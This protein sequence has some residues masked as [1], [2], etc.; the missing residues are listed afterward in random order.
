MPDIAFDLRY[1][2]YAILAAEHGSF[3]RAAEIL[4][5]SQSTV[6]RRIQILERRVGILLF[7]R[8]RSG[9]RATMAG[10][11]FLREAAVGAKH[12]NQAVDTIAQAKRGSI[13]LLRIGLMACIASGFLGELLAAYHRRFPAIEVIFEEATSQINAGA[14]L[15][16]RLDVAFMPGNPQLPGCRSETLW[17]E[18]IYLAVPASHRIVS[19]DV[20]GWEDVCHETFL[21]KADATRPEVE[22]YLMRQL[23]GAGLS[24]KISVQQIGCENLLSIVAQGFGITLAT[25]SIV[26]NVYPGVR[27]VPIAGGKETFS[28]SAVWSATN[29]N[30]ALKFLIDMS[31]ERRRKAKR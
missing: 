4:S 28:F 15:D 30:P 31:I 11:R 27:F 1:L 25:N 5:V 16:G 7:D 2:R 9:A 21:V 10:E 12:L 8:H 20:A 6:S 23:C 14:L 24:P 17:D 13:G 29:P 22:D 26:G 18:T 3:R 19:L